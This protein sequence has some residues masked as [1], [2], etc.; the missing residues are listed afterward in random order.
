L[1]PGAFLAMWL[2]MSVLKEAPSDV[3]NHNFF[4]IAAQM[5]RGQGVA[6]SPT[7]LANL[8]RGHFSLKLHICSGNEEEFVADTP[9]NVLQLWILERFPSLKSKVE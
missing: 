5:A 6:L 3:V 2:S 8:Y 7:A 4:C 9:L 1:E